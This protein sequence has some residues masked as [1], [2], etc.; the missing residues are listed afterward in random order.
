LCHTVRY[1]LLLLILISYFTTALV[2][3]ASTD[4]LSLG[5]FWTYEIAS[6]SEL[7]GVGEYDGRF[8][9]T[10][11]VAGRSV[12]RQV[13]SS[14]LI[15]EKREKVNIAIDGSGHYEQELRRDSYEFTETSTI[16]RQTL[17]YKSRI[18]Q[19][20]IENNEVNDDSI[21]GMPATEFVST[22]LIE[23][24][25]VPYLTI[26]GR[27]NCSTSYEVISIQGVD[28][29]GITL[30]YSG[31]AARDSWLEADGKADCIFK[32]EKTTGLLASSSS[33]LAVA[34]QKGTRLTVYTYL[35]NSTSLWTTT[36]T[37]T[38]SPTKSS[39]PENI[40]LKTTMPRE[41]IIT[42]SPGSSVIAPS[43]A[44][45]GIVAA[46]IFIARYARARRQLF[47]AGSTS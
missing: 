19:N 35:L 39:T 30:R 1:C 27:V 12:L 43:L 47:S 5:A 23:G 24:Q 8:N 20:E 40:P 25:Y 38:I 7:Q 36:A 31:P 33:K 15:I 9:T 21:T 46:L 41:E 11:S 28:L 29:Q 32:F 14:I 44:I 18:V 37:G 3:Q 2:G 17:T 16:D 34:S 6:R 13:N 4:A 22:A 10:I 42:I 45:I 26:G